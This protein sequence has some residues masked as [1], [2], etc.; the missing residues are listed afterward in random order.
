MEIIVFLA[1]FATSAHALEAGIVLTNVW[2][3][4]V[5]YKAIPADERPHHRLVAW[6]VGSHRAACRRLRHQ[7]WVLP[8]ELVE[9]HKREAIAT[10][11][12]RHHREKFQQG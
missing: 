7:C 4:R 11:V 12:M 2:L 1:H 5:T 8:V 10:E 3:C 6:V 9:L